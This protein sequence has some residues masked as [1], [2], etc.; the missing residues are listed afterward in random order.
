M[1]IAFQKKLD[2]TVTE[3][4]D[5]VVENNRVGFSLRQR[6]LG[7]GSLELERLAVVGIRLIPMADGLFRTR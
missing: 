5:A 2:E 6:Y 1:R 4:A 7:R 3:S